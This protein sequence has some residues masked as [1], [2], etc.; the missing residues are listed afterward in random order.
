MFYL[1]SCNYIKREKKKLMK[2]WRIRYVIVLLNTSRPLD[3]NVS[4][5]CSK[6]HQYMIEYTTSLCNYFNS[7]S[8]IEAK[9]VISTIR[10]WCSI[11]MIY[12]TLTYTKRIYLIYPNSCNER[13][14]AICSNVFL[15][16]GHDVSYLWSWLHLYT[17][18]YTT[19]HVTL[20]LIVVTK[21]KIEII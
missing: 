9:E 4:Y 2:I 18:E 12:I 10:S 17:K 19:S 7:N 16:L 11:S 15:P 13:K 5:L 14:D 8:C 20:T 6:S 1:N 21:D 3:H